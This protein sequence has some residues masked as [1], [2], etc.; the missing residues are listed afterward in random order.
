MY[1]FAGFQA[2]TV[3]NQFIFFLQDDSSL[4]AARI[5]ASPVLTRDTGQVLGTGKSDGQFGE[6][7]KAINK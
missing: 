3:L 2:D 1:I 5:E 7:P 4:E 6:Q